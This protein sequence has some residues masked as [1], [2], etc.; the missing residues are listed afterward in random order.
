MQVVFGGQAT[1]ASGETNRILAAEI[2]KPLTHTDMVRPVMAMMRRRPQ[3]L[4]PRECADPR[5]CFFVEPLVAQE[6][7]PWYASLVF[8]D[9][10]GNRTSCESVF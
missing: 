2:E 1:N 6:G 7:K 8:V 5:V 10:Q 9:Q 3:T 4:S